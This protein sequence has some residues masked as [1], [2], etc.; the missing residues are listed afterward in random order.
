MKKL[1]TLIVFSLLV[2]SY[3]KAQTVEVKNVLGVCKLEQ[4]GKKFKLKDLEP[5]FKFDQEALG[6][7]KKTRRQKVGLFFLGTAAGSA[8]GIPVGMAL[9][10]EK[11]DWTL[12]GVGLGLTAITVPLYS[13]YNKRITHLASLYNEKNIGAYKNRFQP[14]MELVASTNMAG[15]KIF[16]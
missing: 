9:G 6:L 7:L 11:M 3:G 12:L 13:K 8:V 16:F 15:I 4:A 2:F 14:R 10:G 1:I 5:A